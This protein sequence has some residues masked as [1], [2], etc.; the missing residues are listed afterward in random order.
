MVEEQAIVV[1]ID[2]SGVWVETQRQ[3]ACGSCAAKKG[4]GSAALEKMF[5]NK[6]NIVRVIGELPVKIGDHVVVGLEEDALV[7]GSML[8]YALPILL[9]ILFGY[10][11][12]TILSGLLSMNS[13]LASILGAGT[14]LLISFIWLNRFGLGISKNTRYQPVILRYSETAPAQSNYNLLS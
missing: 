9:I 10:L 7:K 4:C 2:Q 11:G 13:E 8:V 3:S 12:E 5:G 6:R 14:G 1:S